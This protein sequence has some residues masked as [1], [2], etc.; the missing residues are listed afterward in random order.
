MKSLRERLLGRAFRIGRYYAWWVLVISLL[1]TGLG[2]Y[3]AR[4]VPLRSSLFD[5]LPTDDPVI[6]EYRQN[7]Q[8][9]AESDDVGL[10]VTLVGDIPEFPE[11]RTSRLLDAAE[12]I[13]ESLEADPDGEFTEVRYL[14]EIS[15]E[16]PDQY[17]NLFELDA[18]ELLRIEQSVELARGAIS[19]DAEST[20]LPDGTT[21]GA[22]YRAISQ[23]FSE[24]LYRGDFTDA[25]DSGDLE[26]IR[27]QLG[28]VGELNDG[29]L[30]AIDGLPGLA[31]VT[32]AVEDL[33]GIFAPT[34]REGSREPI[35]FLSKDRLSLLM[36]ARPRLPSSMGVEYSTLVT[37]KVDA[38]IA[39]ANPEALGVSV[40]VTGTYPFN[41]STS[42]VVNADMVRTT[43]ISSIGVF[44]IFLLAF[45]SILYSVVAVVPLL[46]SVVLTIGWAKA[47]VGGFNLVTTFLPALILGLGIDYAI[48]LISRYSEERSRGKSL[49][50]ALHAAVL[51]KGTASFVAATTTCFVFLGLLTAKSRALFE[52]GAITS[53]G[54]MV[55]FFVTLLLLP[56]MITLAHYLFRL[57]LRETVA[58]YAT[59]MTGVFRFVTGRGRAIF[60]IVL[61]L[62]FFVA[63]QAGRTSFIFSSTDLVPH[64]ESQD[65]MTEILRD[66]EVSPA[67]IGSFFTFYASSEAELRDIVERLSEHE[68]V[69]AVDSAVGILPVNLTEQQRTLNTLDIQAYVDQLRLLEASL[70]E[71]GTVISEIRGLLAQ[72]ALLQYGASLN[73]LP[74]IAL[75]SNHNLTQLRRIQLQLSELDVRQAAD[76]VASLRLALERLDG[77]LETVRDLP[78]VETLLRDILLAYPEGIRARYL[79]PDGDFVVQARVSRQI[80]DRG[81]LAEF[82]RFAESF[83][84]DYFGM[85]LVAQRLEEYMKRD[86]YLSTALACVLIL[87]VLRGSLRGWVRA[88]LAATPLVLGYVWMLGGMRLLSIDFN[89]LSITISPLL[90]G[91]GVDNGIHILHRTIEE[92]L[93]QPD[94]AIERGASTTAIAVAV[95][96]LTTMLVFGSLLA[97]RTPGLRLLGIS[98][99]LGIGFSLIFSLL[100]LPAAL[101]V[102]GGRRV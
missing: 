16:I 21:L 73:G 72:F 1:L 49:N 63:F 94:G 46:I 88:L 27:T 98:A 11:E 67:G 30:L 87:L 42:R 32:A 57:R 65:V 64:V 78:P 84:D 35:P 8:Y 44:V 62:T 26:E 97:A 23:A 56:A 51:H 29:V 71:R 91:I 101:R 99:L 74:E 17:L 33:T 10:L 6:D 50:R 69:E 92:R 4:D 22:A 76:S 3:Y 61:V 15:P 39:R 59:R 82:D 77:E 7:E 43:V 25:I 19:G 86:F 68:L 38:A 18:A 58:N 70:G 41:A 83:S 60:V 52:M 24:A 20:R 37:E 79:T 54:V 80:Y 55:A 34:P 31:S 45:G 9:M 85:P 28:S 81:N 95:T 48:H 5:L 36:T 47:S 53:V 13:K 93:V 75:A 66:F 2:V 90:I 14:H 89:F 100:F 12:R 40:G 102:E 96:S